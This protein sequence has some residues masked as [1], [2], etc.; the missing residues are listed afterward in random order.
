ME[1]NEFENAVRGYKEEKQERY[2]M[3]RIFAVM[4]MQVHMPKGKKL[5]PREVLAFPWETSSTPQGALRAM[6][7]EEV[8]SMKAN[9]KKNRIK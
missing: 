6:S 2:E 5:E 7:S 8:E 4:Q 1:P 3:D 9:M